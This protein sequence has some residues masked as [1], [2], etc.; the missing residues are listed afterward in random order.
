MDDQQ[1]LSYSR[2]IL[3]PEISIEMEAVEV[4]GYGSFGINRRP[5]RKGCNPKTGVAVM[6]SAKYVPHFKPCKE[7]RERANGNCRLPHM[8]NCNN[9]RFVVALKHG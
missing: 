7:L 2:H 1:S 5:L 3:L 9:S 4:R 8:A 6:V